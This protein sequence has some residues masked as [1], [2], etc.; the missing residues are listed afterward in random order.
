MR[1]FILASS[2]LTLSACNNTE[3]P[4]EGAVGE[5]NAN[6]TASDQAAAGSVAATNDSASMNPTD[7]ASY[8]KKAGAG[9][10]W[11]IASSKAVL[12]KTKNADVKKFAQMMVDHHTRGTEK[13]MAAAKAG[14]VDAAPPEM[15]AMQQSML[16]D[17]TNASASDMDAMYVK[18][19]QTAHQAALSMHENFA[20]NGTNAS[21]KKAAS[22]SVGVVKS[23]ISE[24]QKLSASVGNS[25]KG[26]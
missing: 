2:L 16:D 25:A 14:S 6:V 1:Y 10:S 21:L 4:S 12:A 3:S 13:L 9:D 11:E 18:H 24:L 23:H 19:Q 8:L 5:S 17:I 7:A 20:L 22:E 26:S 15:D